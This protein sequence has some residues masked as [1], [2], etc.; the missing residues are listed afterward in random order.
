MLKNKF[1][2]A[3]LKKNN[4][5]LSIQK[6]SLYGK[7]KRGQILVKLKYSGIC[8]KQIDEIKGVGGKDPYLPHLLGHEGSGVV[9]EIGPDV[10]KVQKKDKVILHWIKSNGIQSETPKYILNNKSINAG[11]VTTFNEYA[12]VSENRVTKIPKGYPLK[13]AS[14]FGCCATTSLSLVYNELNLT[15]KDILL[16]VG[17]GGLGQIIL[18]AV[19]N[20]NTKKV[21]AA[22]IN[23]SALKKAKKFGADL[24]IDLNKKKDIEQINNLNI[25]K[26]VVTTGNKN[27]I[28]KAIKLMSLPGI[29]YI[30]GV[31]PKKSSI[32]INA[33]NL[34]HDQTIKGCLGG[35]ANPQKDIPKFINLDE[36][37]LINLNQTI[38]KTI[39]LEEINK[40][41]QMFKNKITTGRILIKF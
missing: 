17:I 37:K 38:S 35:N 27:A 30:M 12:I 28:E 16:V 2:A 18:Q 3:I 34:M 31:P 39:K 25:N 23:L 36:K 6:I 11:Y 4:S 9:K 22:D 20:F 7:L 13:K 8:G 1:K 29:C 26:S 14:L 21:I 24:I 5:Q 19:K 10:K 41:I 15:K 33:W 40:G 32:K